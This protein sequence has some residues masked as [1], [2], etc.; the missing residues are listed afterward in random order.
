MT[1]RHPV[2][3]ISRLNLV[4]VFVTESTRAGCSDAALTGRLRSEPPVAAPRPH[5]RHRDGHPEDESADMGEEGDTA[6]AA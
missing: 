4:I 1:G 6:A 5:E 3:V 2:C